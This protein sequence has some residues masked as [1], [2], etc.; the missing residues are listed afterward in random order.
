[1]FFFVLSDIL[2]YNYIVYIV[3]FEMT[4]KEYVIKVL[5]K[6][7]P[8]WKEASSIKDKILSWATQE[9][10]EDM[11]QKCVKAVDVTLDNQQTESAQKLGNYL[12]TLQQQ[13][14]LSQ[15]ADEQD[16]KKLEVLLA[17]L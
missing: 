7:I 17:T 3:C 4:K 5:D 15:Q 14:Q 12:Q 6:V 8:Y 1:M 9:Y 13:E 10:I 2:L 16:I 11:Y